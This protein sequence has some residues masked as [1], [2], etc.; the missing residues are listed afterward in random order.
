MTTTRPVQS[1]TEALASTNTTDQRK[2]SALAAL[3]TSSGNSN[4]AIAAGF[5][6]SAS[7]LSDPFAEIFARIAASEPVA[8]AEPV[9]AP[10][11][12]E[13]EESVR[14]E[15]SDDSEDQDTEESTTVA[16]VVVGNEQATETLE[17]Q[18][19]VISEAESEGQEETSHSPQAIEWNESDAAGEETES[20]GELEVISEEETSI[21]Q[22]T[23]EPQ[24]VDANE[25]VVHEEVAVAAQSDSRQRQNEKSSETVV[26]DEAFAE[27]TISTT[28][29]TT[30]STAEIESAEATTSDEQ[31]GDDAAHDIRR[32][33]R[34]RY[35]DSAPLQNNT[36]AGS[37]ASS[38]TAQTSGFS[39]APELAKSAE[40]S[41]SIDPSQF[42]QAIDSAAAKSA[43][44]ASQA[45]NATSA[46]AAAARAAT[47]SSA[48]ASSTTAAS[49]TTDPTTPVT[50]T[51]ASTAKTKDAQQTGT[52]SSGVDQNSAVARAKL[53]QR[54]SRG[55]Q[56]LGTNGGHI[57]M[58]LSP[59]ELGSVRLEVHIQ[60]NTL[61]GR[62]VTES[63][64][65]SQ[66]L[67]ERL[68]QLRSQLESQGMRLESI[69]ITTDAGGGSDFDSSQSFSGGDASA[70][71]EHFQHREANR[72]KDFG[73]R[74]RAETAPLENTPVAA[75]AVGWNSSTTGVDVRA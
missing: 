28:E 2:H 50:G 14:A 15:S 48:A 39:I 6:E 12:I 25:G 35:S 22:P 54:V 59:V 16:A 27:S 46:V 8:A 38:P 45:V 4:P 26:E 43:T 42:E 62:M 32:T 23:T 68:P 5:A 34:R 57:R 40:S 37:Q 44:P 19:E 55:F 1:R 71:R 72:S 56:S 67:R 73:R 58:R 24:A 30:A 52:K 20:A 11:E 53:V 13:R 63:E 10:E 64:A 3:S 7:G 17:T 51:E 21:A 9:A 70:D 29:E 36:P 69:E 18:T 65:A 31:S 33:E 41:E 66:V 61:R 49:A 74:Q 75:S 60:D 47:G